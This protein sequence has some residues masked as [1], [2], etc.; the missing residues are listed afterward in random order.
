MLLIRACRRNSGSEISLL[1]DQRARVG[2]PAYNDEYYDRFYNLTGAILIRQ[3]TDAATDVGS[4]WLT[5]WINAGRPQLPGPVYG[6]VMNTTPLERFTA[7]PKAELHVHLEG[8]IE[9]PDRSRARRTARRHAHGS[10][11]QRRVTPRE[12][13]R[14]L[15]RPFCG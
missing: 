9:P 8:S 6:H 11:R 12:I 14:N 13:L 3:L 4:Y 10:K 7:L 1:A 5:A 2:L 15:L